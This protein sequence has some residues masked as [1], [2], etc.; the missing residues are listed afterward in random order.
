M[1]ISPGRTQNLVDDAAALRDAGCHQ[2]ILREPHRTRWEIEN[3]LPA[4]KELLP[5]LILHAKNINAWRFA[6]IYKTG[7][8]LPS[9]VDPKLWRDRFSGLLGISCHNLEEVVA[10]QN[11]GLDYALLSPIFPPHSKVDPRTPLGPERAASIQT[12]TSL[13]LFGLG[14]MH[15][16]KVAQ[17]RGLFGVAS[18]GHLFGTRTNRSRQKARTKSFLDQLQKQHQSVGQ[19]KTSC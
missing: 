11:A 2:L 17:C 1:P 3:Q 9:H 4:L 13:P 7:L 12:A 14:G 19:T 8:H 15:P 16:K 6:E 18:L 5:G 10:A